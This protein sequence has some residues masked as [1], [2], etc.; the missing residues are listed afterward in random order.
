MTPMCS[1]TKGMDYFEKVRQIYPEIHNYE[2][3]VKGDQHFSSCGHMN[4]TGAR[5]FTNIIIRDF[6]N[7]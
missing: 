6:F 2:D 1:N 7:K 4:D 5:M 3:A